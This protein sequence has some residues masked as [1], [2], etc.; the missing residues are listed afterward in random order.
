MTTKR[1]ELE[2]ADEISAARRQFLGKTGRAG[3]LALAAPALAANWTGEAFGADK[4]RAYSAGH[5]ALEL[6]G[7]IAGFLT[8][9][10]GGS[11]VGDVM[12][13][14]PDK[15]FVQ[16]KR[17]VGYRVEPITIEAAPSMSKSFYEWI[18]SS[19]E[20]RPRFLRKN[21]AI[22][23]LDSGY[24]ELGRRI[25]TNA[26]ITEV[27]FPGCDASSKDSAGIA[28][29]FSPEKV[30]LSPAKGGAFKHDPKKEK[31]VRST[32]NLQ[33]Q[34]L[35]SGLKRTAKIEPIEVKIATA[36][37]A[38]GAERL[39]SVQPMAIEVP[40]LV[41]TIDASGVA[42]FYAWH[43]DFVIRGN[44]SKERERTGV[45]NYLSSDMKSVLF[46]LNFFNLGILKV[47]PEAA[48]TTGLQETMR[49]YKAE[50]YCEAITAD[51][52]I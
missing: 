50:M 19:I 26:L 14:K 38:V 45:L 51:F 47:A 5:Y 52:K 41:I 21:G 22:V 13:E 42:P 34:G 9:F 49:R 15:D 10:S 4:S 25:F 6:D 29:T 44:N 46:T 28:V 36:P 2:G 7:A 40:N 23:E 35:E 48:P 16:Q 1:D 32:F 3:F 11:A 39:S 8:G 18:K 33:I 20:P 37:A 31:W 12:K 43:E 30:M 27:E 17:L 24:R